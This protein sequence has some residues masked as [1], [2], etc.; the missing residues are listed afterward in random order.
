MGKHTFKAH[1]YRKGMSE[2]MKIAELFKAKRVVYSF[3]V[4]PP[5]KSSSVDSVYKTLDGLKEFNPDYI[6]VTYGAGASLSDNLT[7]EIS[8][9]IKNKLNIETMAHLTCINSSE[10][11]VNETIEQLQKREIENILALRGDINPDVEPLKD[12]RYAVDLIDYIKKHPN[13]SEMGICGACYPEGHPTA[14]SLD[15]DIEFLKQKVDAGAQ[16]LVT[17]LLFDNER[18][19]T[20]REKI[21][22]VGIDV[23]VSVGIMPI[24]N[25]KQIERMVT[26]CAVSLPPKFVKIMSRYENNPEALTDAGI[27]YAVEQIVELLANDVRGI[28]LYTMNRQYVAQKVT[29]AIRTMI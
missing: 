17:Q 26:L 20:F 10:N 2:N 21:E 27:A 16:T 9:Y 12:F 5:K 25:K 13:F 18:F 15:E 3:E 7:A 24:T 29:D 14:D 11:S 22:K 19:Y 4:F 6:S 1:L 8:G 28:H 23:P